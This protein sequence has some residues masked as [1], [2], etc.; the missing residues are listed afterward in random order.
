LENTPLVEALKIKRVKSAVFWDVT[1][2]NLVESESPMFQTNV[3]APF[4]G[5]EGC[6]LLVTMA[7][8][9]ETACSSEAL[10]GLYDVTHSRIV[11]T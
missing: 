3:L 9:I 2:L 11:T 10:M 7:M 5:P 8:I 4:R 1:W 6:L